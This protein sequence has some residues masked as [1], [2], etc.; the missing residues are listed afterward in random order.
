MQVIPSLPHHPAAAF[1]NA[2]L[3]AR[4]FLGSVTSPVQEGWEWAFT[5]GCEQTASTGSLFPRVSLIACGLS[6]AYPSPEHEKGHC[7]K[8]ASKSPYIGLC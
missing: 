3:T 4:Y 7:V 5:W 6:S 2:A 1:C 8:R